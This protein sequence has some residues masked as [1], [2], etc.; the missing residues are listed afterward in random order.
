MAENS[1]NTGLNGYNDGS[2]EG[3]LG[4][5]R[6]RLQQDALHAYRPADAVPLPREPDLAYASNDP[7][8]TPSQ[9][10][11]IARRDR[12][13]STAT[14]LLAL[15]STL[16]AA[17]GAFVLARPYAVAFVDRYAFEGVTVLRCQIAAAATA[18]VVWAIMTFPRGLLF[19]HAVAAGLA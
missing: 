3:T 19:N 1:Y 8:F 18:G 15:S 2:W 13:V 17:L 16:V 9:V 7:G 11:W 14:V 4:Y 6:Y 10:A 5:H 12:W